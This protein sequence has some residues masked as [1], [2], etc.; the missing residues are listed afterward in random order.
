[1][2]LVK[3]KHC[4]VYLMI[5]SQRFIQCDFS[6]SW[7]GCDRRS[8]KRRESWCLT[9]KLQAAANKAIVFLFTLPLQLER[10]SHA[11]SRMLQDN[12]FTGWIHLGFVTDVEHFFSPSFGLSWIFCVYTFL[13]VASVHVGRV[14][15]TG[16]LLGLP[17]QSVSPGH[18]LSTAF[19]PDWI[20]KWR[21]SKELQRGL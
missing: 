17:R 20:R 13:L 19:L 11:F 2:F 14:P 10:L 8:V 5:K 7:F 6:S 9:N 16:L 1:M 12:I 3:K 4:H 15:S 21:E 18:S